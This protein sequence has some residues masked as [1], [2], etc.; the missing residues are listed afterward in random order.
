[1][2]RWGF[3]YSVARGHSQQAF[4]APS[5]TYVEHTVALASQYLHIVAEVSLANAI[6]ATDIEPDSIITMRVFRDAAH[7]NDTYGASVF[8]LTADL[9]YERDRGSTPNKSPDF[10]A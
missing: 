9:H 7:V 5:T 6:P 8:G 10:Y 4:P 1:M 2:V 3:E